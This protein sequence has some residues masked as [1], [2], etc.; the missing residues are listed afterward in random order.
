MNLSAANLDFYQP[1]DSPV[2]RLAPRVKVVW[3]LL[4]IASNLLIADGA[5]PAFALSAGLALF[6]SILARLNPARI[7]RRSLVALPFALAAVTVIFSTAGQTLIS[8]QVGVWRIVV[9]DT[10][11]WRFTG[12]ITR[13]WLSMLGVILLTATTRFPDLMHALR[14]LKLPAS[15]VAIISFTYRYFF[16]LNDEAIR[17]LRAREARSARLAGTGGLGGSVRQRARVAG[18]MVGQLF[19]RS[20]ERSARVYQAMLARGYRGHIQTL[21]PHTIAPAD[22]L[23]GGL[24]L[25]A[26]ILI[27]L[28]A[29]RLPF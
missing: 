16:V 5:W 11:L 15:L 29:R 7:F 1:A 2:H 19:L 21:A 23:G 4:F 24:G 22:W 12:I 25:L 27:Q 14:H 10:G 8:G 9:T 18:Y 26:L 28:A 6:L 20:Y 17:L 3:T 13:S